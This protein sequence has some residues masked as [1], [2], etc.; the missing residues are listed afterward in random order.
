MPLVINT[1]LATH[2]KN[3]AL[4]NATNSVA[5]DIKFRGALYS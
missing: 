4:L 1:T 2:S 3:P 5:A